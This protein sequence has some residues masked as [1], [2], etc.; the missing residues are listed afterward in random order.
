MYKIVIAD[1][2][3]ILLYG[4]STSFDWQSLGIQVV[5]SVDDGD[6]A[7]REV[8]EKR[9]D[10]LLTDIKMTHTNG[11][12][13]AGK[14]RQEC[15]DVHIVIMSAYDDFRF[16][17]QALRLGVVDYLL[18][19]IDLGQL[20]ETMKHIVYQKMKE[21]QYPLG[22]AVGIQK[23]VLEEMFFQ[24]LL[25]HRYDRE[26]YLQLKELYVEDGLLWRAVEVIFDSGQIREAGIKAVNEVAKKYGYPMVSVFGKHLVCCSGKIEAIISRIKEFKRECK[27]AVKTILPEE[28]LSFLNGTVVEDAFYLSLSY[29]KILQIR[30]YQYSAGNEADLSEQDLDRYF[31]QHH[32]LNKTQIGYLVRLVVLGNTDAIPKYMEKIKENLK[33]AGNDSLLML[34]L[35]LSYIFAKLESSLCAEDS[36][37]ERLG[38][39]Y[40]EAISQKTLDHAI[41]ILQKRL[42]DLS[43]QIMRGG[44]FTHEQLVQ[45]AHAY[46]D[47]HYKNSKLRIT[48]VAEE[49]GLSPNYLSTIFK[50]V[51]GDNFT[52]YLL[53]KRM[54]EAQ[55]L[56]GNSSH[57][58]QEIGYLVGYE[59]PAYFSSVFKKFVGVTVSQYRE[60]VH[61]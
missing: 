50:E 20:T 14:L 54:W 9:A 26:T 43:V 53:K 25:N 39:L 3:E 57:S 11:L 41:Q 19:P 45:R 42:M 49:V 17:Q 2:D 40:K 51:T 4:I 1:D 58:S 10:I 36:M 15:P 12:D 55:V 44:S 34:S 5:A 22:G 8:R 35:S 24:N 23:N 16:A 6:K 31:N 52:D 32:M 33:N 27:A 48:D 13:L 60:M 37:A 38:A 56:L 46:I 21:S 59:N 29:E 7:L 47:E 18:K 28:T 30:E 61:P